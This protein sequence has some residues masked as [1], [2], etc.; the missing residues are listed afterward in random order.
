M[1]SKRIL[2]ALLACLFLT[3]CNLERARIKRHAMEYVTTHAKAGD[4]YRWNRVER[5]KNGIS[6]ADKHC[7]YAQVTFDVSQSDGRTRQDTLYL[8]FTEG[9][10]ELLSVS[11]QCDE[12]IMPYP[13]ISEED[14][15]KFMY[16]TFTRE[17]ETGT[18]LLEKEMEEIV[19]KET[20]E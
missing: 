18:T 5:L 6:Y 8:L 9:C 7:E 2:Y 1:R 11:R 3:A 15:K 16:K 12:R 17:S 4:T 13:K 19:R 20:D 14:I 10:K